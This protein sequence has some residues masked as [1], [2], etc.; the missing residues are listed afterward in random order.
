MR[1]QHLTHATANQFLRHYC[2]QAGGSFPVF[3]GAPYQTG[4]GFGNILRSIGRFLLPIIAPTASSFIRSAAEGLEGGQDIK[5]ALK[6]SIAPTV[7]T[8]LG[9]TIE[10]VQ[11]RQSGSGKRRHKRKVVRKK[12]Y[13]ATKAKRTH[14][15]KSK[16]GKRKKSRSKIRSLN[17]INF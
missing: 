15:R 16:S 9:S 14:K 12:L 1:P 6:G 2:Q 11:K 5:S 3:A 8:A 10:Q 4:A 7:K 17:S 13:K